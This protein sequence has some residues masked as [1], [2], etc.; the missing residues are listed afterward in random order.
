MAAGIADFPMGAE[1][2]APAV[3]DIV[4]DFVLSGMQPV[5]CSEG[6]TVLSEDVTYSGACLQ[7]FRK[8]FVT[9]EYLH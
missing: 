9:A 5:F 1:V 3:F 6:I 2:P 7:L 8:W 4:H